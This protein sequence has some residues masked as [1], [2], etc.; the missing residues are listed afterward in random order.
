[1]LHNFFE[2][3]SLIKEGASRDSIIYWKAQLEEILDQEW[4]EIKTEKR[5]GKNNYIY[6]RVKDKDEK[7][8]FYSVITEKV[9]EKDKD[10]FYMEDDTS[11]MFIEKF[12]KEFWKNPHE[13]IKDMK[14]HPKCLGDLGHVEMSNKFNM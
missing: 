12:K 6:F 8:N 4:Y 1:M 11:N 9:A 7:Y 5:A 13:Y 14:Y 10:I 3:V 2:Y